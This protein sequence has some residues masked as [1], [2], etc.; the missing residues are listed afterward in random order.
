MFV[1]AMQIYQHFSQFAQLLH[2]GRYTV[3]KGFGRAVATDGAAN[4]ALIFTLHLM[5]TQPAYC[6]RGIM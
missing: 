6:L 5:F 2:G 3:D 4:D 1:L